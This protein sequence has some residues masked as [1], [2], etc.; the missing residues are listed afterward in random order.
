MDDLLWNGSWSGG[1]DDDGCEENLF[2][3]D[4]SCCSSPPLKELQTVAEILGL[5]EIN[6][7]ASDM[8]SM[9]LRKPA[10]VVDLKLLCDRGNSWPA[11]ASS[12]GLL[13]E[14]LENDKG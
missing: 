7:S 14:E 4:P 3:S 11:G 10:G 5:P 6:N 8:G 1:G 2:I 12:G 13:L 9:A